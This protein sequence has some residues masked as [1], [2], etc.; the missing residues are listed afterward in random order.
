MTARARRQPGR[1]KYPSRH[2]IIDAA[3]G[4]EGIIDWG[5][6]HPLIVEHLVIALHVLRRA[7]RLDPPTAHVAVGGP[8]AAETPSPQA[9]LAI[10]LC[11][12]DRLLDMP[13]L[14]NAKIREP[15][16]TAAALMERAL[17]PG[18]RG[19]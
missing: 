14:V 10:A 7:A 9:D 15:M 1:D 11:L 19:A 5:D 17:G 18:R 8:I 12:L 16:A 4:I 6:E 3:A 13:E 2:D